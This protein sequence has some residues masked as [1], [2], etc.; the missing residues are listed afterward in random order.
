MP[1]TNGENVGPY[2][3]LAN[4]GQ[5]GVA[6]VYKAYHPALDRLV[7]IKVLHPAFK[8]DPNFLERFQ[9]EARVIARLEHPNIVPVYDFSQQ[10]D[11]HYLVMK[12][13]EGETLKARLG[14]APLSMEEGL[15]I[16]ESVGGG[17]MHAHVRGVL[18][19][20]VKPSNILLDNTGRIYLADFGLAR[21]AAAG[22][23]TLSSDMLMGTPQYISPEQA[24]GEKSLDARTDIYSFGVVLYEIV[25]G[26]VPF[27]A[28]TPFSIIHDHIYSPLPLPSSINSRVPEQVERV[29]LKS[30][31]KDRNDRFEDVEQMVSAFRRAAR[32]ED[33]GIINVPAV[34]DTAIGISAPGASSYAQGKKADA[35]TKKKSLWWLWLAAGILIT[36]IS[37]FL[38]LGILAPGETAPL[39]PADESPEQPVLLDQQLEEDIAP[40]QEAADYHREAE[41]LAD[42][43]AR[44]AENG[45]FIQ[46]AEMYLQ[47]LG[48]PELPE[49]AVANYME[50]LYK[51]LYLAAPAGDDVR[52]VLED[53]RG[54]FEGSRDL[55]PVELRMKLFMEGPEH[56]IQEVN[57]VVRDD[58]ENLEMRLLHAEV[59]MQMDRELDFNEDIDFLLTREFLPDWILQQAVSLEE[60]YYEVY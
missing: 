57:Q 31:A 52:F 50:Q 8:E 47:A 53:A 3:I 44:L 39:D 1:F 29:L 48:V 19:R 40:D 13:I 55:R 51:V 25:V 23:S 46:A 27:Q 30:L 56:I 34:E 33:S 36:C 58:P 16:V 7:A 14:R 17:L 11:Q 35:E 37:V 54:R 60:K 41:I 9:R 22:E 12:Y 24:R 2:R 5:G 20:D 59:M 43:A 18:H 42:D 15:K 10:S 38:L 21:I 45:M 26:R 6:S 28:D 4:L 49:E 32:G